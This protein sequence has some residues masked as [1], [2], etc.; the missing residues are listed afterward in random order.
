M[1]LSFVYWPCLPTNQQT[2]LLFSVE[3]L[4]CRAYTGRHTR[5]AA[6]QWAAMM[7]L[8]L[9]A[10]PES[11]ADRTASCWNEL[12][13]LMALQTIVPELSRTPR[14]Y[15]CGVKVCTAKPRHTF[16]CLFFHLK[17][18]SVNNAL[19]LVLMRISLVPQRRLCS[20]WRQF[21]LLREVRIYVALTLEFCRWLFYRKRWTLIAASLKK[22]PT[23]SVISIYCVF[24]VV[25]QEFLTNNVSFFCLLWHVVISHSICLLCAIIP[26]KIIRVWFCANV[27][28]FLP[29]MSVYLT[30]MKG[31]KKKYKSYLLISYSCQ[32]SSNSTVSYS[33]RR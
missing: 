13:S 23:S 19:W 1:L 17:E 24:G 18:A 5:V 28:H 8:L 12:N 14:D 27:F 32:I 9:A 15:H 22:P 30:K 3:C 16:P 11:P 2:V 6:I 20:H 33:I 31:I 7:L 21:Y 10:Q 26:L 29:K 4:F 25:E